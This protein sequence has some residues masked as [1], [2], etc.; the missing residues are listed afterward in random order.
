MHRRYG[1]G[2]VSSLL[3]LPLSVQA[4][5]IE[6]LAVYKDE[7]EL[8]VIANGESVRV[9]PIQLGF[10]PDGP[11]RWQGDGRT[12]EGIYRIS[13][14]NPASQYHLSLR[15]DYPNFSDLQFAERYELNPG[16]DIFLH[17]LP[18]QPNRPLG[19]YQESDW[20]EG[21]IAM[22]NEDIQYL[23]KHVQLQTPIVINP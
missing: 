21:C 14:R 3:F 5:L 12:P 19:D 13:A 22:S 1:W 9:I 8:H 15:V 4:V 23:Y 2:I 18:N 20:T 11:K 6:S 10:D 7:R 17:G 16:G